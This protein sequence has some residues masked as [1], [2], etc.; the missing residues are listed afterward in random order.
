M[1]R[2]EKQEIS[3]YVMKMRIYP[4]AKQ[5]ERLDKAFHALRLAYNMTFHEVFL[6]NPD[7]CVTGKTNDSASDSSEKG[8]ERAEPDFEK[9]SKAAWKRKLIEKNPAVADAPAAAIMCQN[10]L[11]RA[12]AKRAWEA[13]K[14][15]SHG[16]EVERR[17]FHFYSNAK[18]RRSFT[19][20]IKPS[21][22]TVSADRSK[23]AWIKI[24]KSGSVKA[25]G[26]NPKIWFGENGAYT[27][28][29]ACK[30]GIITK[31]DSLLLRVSKDACGAY[32]ASLTLSAATTAGERF[33]MYREVKSVKD[34]MDIGVDVGVK[35]IAILNDGTKYENKQFK[36]AVSKKLKKMNRQLSRRWGPANSSYRD[37]CRDVRKT[38]AEQSEEN[39][40]PPAEISRGYL[41]VREKRARLERKVARRRETYYQQLTAEIV[42]RAK[43]IAIE[44]L[45]VKKMM[46]THKF[47]FSIGDA[48]MSSLL[49]MLRYKAERANVQLKTVGRYYASSQCCSICGKKNPAVK[50]LSIRKWTCSSCHAVH[51]RDINAAINILKYGESQT[52]DELPDEEK[53]DAA[54]KRSSRKRP[55]PQNL[56]FPDQPNLI[57]Q[58]SSALTK[59]NDSRYIIYDEK[60]QRIVDDA[61]GYGYR[62]I[63]NAKNCYKAKLKRAINTI[64]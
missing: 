63:P 30:E 13:L 20:Q 32:Y 52:D 1:E 33:K 29:K 17:Q 57:V 39:Q 34:K 14:K 35:D 53:P 7:V 12:D 15:Q 60:A 9:I 3:R 4:T 48:A 36:S 61:N 23:V 10:G 41:K 11:F 62:S 2:T 58:Y 42:G 28:M 56:I 38:N 45:S 18:P 54:A 47:A 50:D 19:V 46:R 5:A 43:L 31:K 55:P 37:Y 44:T 21:H 24:P 16:G 27:Y 8:C 22:V 59:A 64:S 51:D 26:F 6:K 49:S 40:K 25:R